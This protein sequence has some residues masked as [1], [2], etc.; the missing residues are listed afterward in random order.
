M[1]ESKPPQWYNTLSARYPSYIKALEALGQAV[2]AAGPLDER[3]AE[4]IQLGAAAARR[5]EGA[6]HS[7]A[8]RALD[9]GASPE[10]IR[11][12]LL[13]ITSTAGFPAVAAALSWLE[14]VLPG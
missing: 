3:S 1:A 7:H 10:E 8:R 4:L 9:A 2:R 12:A 14:D 11:H 5:S 13:L 6:V